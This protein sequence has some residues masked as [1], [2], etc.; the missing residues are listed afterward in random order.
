[1]P[2]GALAGRIARAVGGCAVSTFCFAVTIRAQLGL[3]PLFVIQDGA[4]RL[5]GI[6]IGQAGMLIGVLLLLLACLL[7]SWP[8][9]GTFVLPFLGGFL[10]DLMLPR[11]PVIQGIGWRLLA[12]TAA[13]W[14]MTLGG[15]LIISARLGIAAL[16]AVMMGIH[17][18]TR[19][20]IRR[21]R[22]AME[23]AMLA[24]GWLMGGAV[25][26]GSVITGALIGHGLQ[27]WL[28]VLR[29]PA[30]APAPA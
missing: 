3:G 23:V 14:C 30:L 26:I 22:L 2:D 18:I 29:Q 9:P 11:L 24:T 5:L 17:R 15:A 27:F 25:G 13:S 1:M 12:V 16:D 8:G 7:R 20:E 21:V 10:I 19:V 28:R 4:H 6:T